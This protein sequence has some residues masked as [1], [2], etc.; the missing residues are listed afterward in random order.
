MPERAATSQFHLTLPQKILSYFF[1][2]P[3]RLSS[4][5]LDLS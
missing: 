1:K 2:R 4:Y 5:L 3:F